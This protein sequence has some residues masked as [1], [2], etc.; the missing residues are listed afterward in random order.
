MNNKLKDNDFLTRLN[1]EHGTDEQKIALLNQ[2]IDN[3]LEKP[4]NEVDMELV[5]ECMSFIRDLDGGKF[6]KSDKELADGLQKIQSAP[7]ESEPGRARPAKILRP[8]KPFFKVA[9]IFAAAALLVAATLAVAA[10]IGGQPDQTSRPDP[11]PAEPT[12]TNYATVDA[13]YLSEKLDIL[14]PS[15]LPA[16][17]SVENIRMLSYED[18]KVDVIYEFS[19]PDLEFTVCNYNF[20]KYS[21][22]DAQIAL[23]FNGY[24]FG[25]TGYPDGSWKAVCLVNGYAYSVRCANYQIILDVAKNLKEYD[26]E[27]AAV[28]FG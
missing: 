13:M 10:R 20:S 22:T 18:G 5:E 14:Y 6:A 17:V 15:L 26:F 4:E 12:V 3:E 8:R 7:A 27:K 21:V 24:V 9:A 25:F 28:L 16:D 23:E 1:M 11:A 2:I 19:S